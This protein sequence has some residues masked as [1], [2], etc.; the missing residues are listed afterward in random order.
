[1]EVSYSQLPSVLFC[2][3]IPQ[4]LVKMNTILYFKNN[5]HCNKQ[6][7]LLR[8]RKPRGQPYIEDLLKNKNIAIKICA[9]K[10]SNKN[11]CNKNITIKIC[12]LY[13]SKLIKI[14][15]NHRNIVNKL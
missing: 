14:Y 8:K 1:M 5:K 6:V 9:I 4:L 12:I 11:I 2:R 7:Q 13:K 15:K 10:I 3:G